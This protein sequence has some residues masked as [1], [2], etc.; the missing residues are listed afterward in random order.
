M[1]AVTTEELTAAI[2]KHNVMRV[3]QYR[4]ARIDEVDESGQVTKAPRKEEAGTQASSSASA[5]ADVQAASPQEHE[6]GD[7]ILNTTQTDERAAKRA[8]KEKR[9]ADLKRSENIAAQG[10][11]NLRRW[12]DCSYY[13]E[14]T[15]T[16]LH[17]Y[18]NSSPSKDEAENYLIVSKSVRHDRRPSKTQDRP[19]R[20]ELPDGPHQR[21][22]HRQRT[23]VYSSFLGWP[24]G[25]SN[26]GP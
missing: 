17:D 4:W 19:R 6:W 18:W 14:M 26:G 25:L 9:I 23:Q 16:V 3:D 20:P 5:S 1:P 2:E 13:S 10:A 22:L 8:R 12:E 7:S 11:A 21:Q 24:V 15:G